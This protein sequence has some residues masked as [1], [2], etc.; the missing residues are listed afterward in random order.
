MVRMKLTSDLCALRENLARDTQN[1]VKHYEKG[2]H[3]SLGIWLRERTYIPVKLR[4]SVTAFWMNLLNRLP[5][6][7]AESCMLSLELDAVLST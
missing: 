5:S 7:F 3:L 2:I 1:I 4:G 6:L